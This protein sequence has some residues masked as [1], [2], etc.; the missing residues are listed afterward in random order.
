MLPSKKV[1]RTH[2]AFNQAVREKRATRLASLRKKAADA[3]KILDKIFQ[4][5]RPFV[6]DY[7]EFIYDV[8]SGAQRWII[9][10]DLKLADIDIETKLVTWYGEQ[11][12]VDDY[13]ETEVE[14]ADTVHI[15][16]QQTLQFSR[17]SKLIAD[18]HRSYITDRKGFMLATAKML[19][20]TD[21]LNN[22]GRL[23]R[24]NFANYMKSVIRLRVGR[25]KRVMQALAREASP[26]KISY[27]LK[28]A[29]VTNA[30]SK[31]TNKGL[32]L[33]IHADVKVGT[34]S[35]TPPRNRY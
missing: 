35:I 33:S 12:D 2:Q 13:D 30:G 34:S 19:T 26:W 14:V 4:H 21:F 6:T 8:A 29:E 25:D 5:H 23:V 7:D 28:G 17:W 22:F 10:S 1:K 18:R 3:H 24:Y 15:I 11:R 16:Y 31:A 32:V 27:V 9:D 20:Y